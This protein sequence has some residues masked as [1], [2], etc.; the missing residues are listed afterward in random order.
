MKLWL[1][2]PVK[3]FSEGKSRLADTLDI[4]ERAGLSR[5]LLRNVLQITRDS[6]L[7]TGILVVSRDPAVL[8]EAAKAGVDILL[9]QSSGL[10]PA[11]RAAR[12]RAVEDGADAVLILP[13]DLPLLDAS[14]LDKLLDRVTKPPSIV[15]APS[16]DNGTN[17]LLLYPPH[18]IDFAFGHNSFQRH[19]EQATQADVAVQVVHSSTLALDIDWPADLRLLESSSITTALTNR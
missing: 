13:S 5:R 11:L 4:D 12:D 8:Q 17:A 10:N 9:E 16:H 6:E 14:D 7:F 19:H 18:V 3:P 2:V 15:I 1:L